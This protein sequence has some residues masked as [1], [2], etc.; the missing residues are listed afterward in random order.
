MN[1]L[2]FYLFNFFF[3]EEEFWHFVIKHNTRTIELITSNRSSNTTTI[4]YA[5]NILV[6]C[7][8]HTRECFRYK[9]HM[10]ISRKFIQFYC[11]VVKNQNENTLRTKIFVWLKGWLA[12]V[13]FN[14]WKWMLVSCLLCKI[15]WFL[16]LKLKLEK[17]VDFMTTPYNIRPY[18]KYTNYTFLTDR[19]TLCIFLT[20]LN[21]LFCL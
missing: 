16:M 20:N 13:S 12:F 11:I 5:L 7:S 2:D 15:C 1:I 17:C 9:R 6:F 8:S 10:N 4:H 14:I 18:L 21:F 3:E 19:H